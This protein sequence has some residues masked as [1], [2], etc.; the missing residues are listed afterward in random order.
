MSRV[1]CYSNG[2]LDTGLLLVG[3]M[4]FYLQWSS[5][6]WVPWFCARLCIRNSI[7][8]LPWSRRIRYEKITR[9]DGSI[10]YVFWP[11]R[12][13]QVSRYSS[14]TTKDDDDGSDKH[15]A[16]P[17]RNDERNWWIAKTAKDNARGVIVAVVRKLI[18]YKRRD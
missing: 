8:S 13:I 1:R 6:L 4:I 3:K 10:N 7:S 14:E 18:A 11:L 9:N 16:W 17:D 15:S 2:E 5:K 12:R